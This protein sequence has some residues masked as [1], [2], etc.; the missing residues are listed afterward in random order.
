MGT[1][2][3]VSSRYV[4]NGSIR[5]E[6]V[7]RVKRAIEDATVLGVSVP[8]IRQ[9]LTP[10]IAGPV[11]IPEARPLA[12]QQR[13]AQLKPFEVGRKAIEMATGHCQKVLTS[14]RLSTLGYRRL[15][16]SIPDTMS[17]INMLLSVS[18][19]RDQQ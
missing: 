2:A 15:I 8:Y 10:F 1:L 5:A 12:Q 13:Q 7:E 16:T 14:D 11:M 4:Q 17:S 3:H 9:Y 19:I 18:S 6:Y